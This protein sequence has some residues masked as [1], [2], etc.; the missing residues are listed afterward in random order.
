MFG[1]APM[2]FMAAVAA[3]FLFPPF[4]SETGD[5][6]VNGR[7]QDRTGRGIFLGVHVAAYPRPGAR[8]IGCLPA[9]AVGPPADGA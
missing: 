1:F 2:A 7:A 9:A 5:G 4:V 3:A 8:D 6:G